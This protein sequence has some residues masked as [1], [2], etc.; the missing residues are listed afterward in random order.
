MKE[1]RL[2][3]CGPMKTHLNTIEMNGS[4]T[5]IIC[6]GATYQYVKEALP[7]ASILKLGVTWPLPA[8]TLE[9]FAQSVEQVFVVEEASDYLSSQ[10]R[11]LGVNLSNPLHSL[12]VDGELTPMLIRESFGFETPKQKS[13]VKDL[14]NRPPALCPGCPH[15][16]VFKELKRAR[17]IITGDIGCYTLGGVTAAFG[18]GY[19]C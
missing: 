16:L 7:Q 11:A 12:P 1:S 9:T 17:A 13:T 2:L 8:K 19:L 10:V 5:G 6:A 4:K 3:S 15:R 14:P 18:Y